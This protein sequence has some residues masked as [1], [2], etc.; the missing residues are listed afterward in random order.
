MWFLRN[1]D[2]APVHGGG[3]G[4]LLGPGHRPPSEPIE[5]VGDRHPDTLRNS[6][7]V[8]ER[9]KERHWKCRVRFFRT[10]GSNPTLS[11]SGS[12]RSRVG[13]QLGTGCSAAW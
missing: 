1:D 6:G 9:L 5:V 12:T 3:R 8:S 10:V 13:S 11:A 7:Q 2:R 4:N